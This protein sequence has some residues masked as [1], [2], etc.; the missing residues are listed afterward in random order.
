M[1]F[2]KYICPIILF[3]C[4][5][6]AF[7]FSALVIW[8][9]GRKETENRL[10]AALCLGSAIWSV[11]FG[12][13]FLQTDPEIAYRCRV[14]GMIGTILYLITGVVLV[15]Y[16]SEIKKS[17]ARVIN[18]FASTGVVIYFLTVERSQTIYQ[19]DT[20]GMTYSFKPGLANTIYTI[21]SIV[22]AVSIFAVSLYMC[23]SK[24][25]RIRHFGK[26]F[27]LM[28]GIIL[29]GTILDT[30]FPLLG[31]SAIPGSTITQFWGAIVVF[32]AIRANNRSK[33][34]IG[35]MSEY[36]YYSLSIPVLV[37][38]STRTLK[39]ANDAAA[40]FFK[41]KQETLSHENVPLDSLFEAEPEALFQFEG[42][43][44][45]IDAVFHA[46]QTYCNLS[47]NKI[48]DRYNDVIGY[49]I[50]VTDLS[51]RMKTMQ[52]LEEAKLEAESANRAKTAFLANMSHEIRTPMNA[53]M[54]FSELI[55]KMDIPDTV[56]EYVSDIRSSSQNL[57]AIINDIL[58]ISKLDSGK[59]E[60][61]CTNYLPHTLL[62]DVYHIIDVQARKKGLH[63][64]MNT[65]PR[66]PNELYGDVAR[67]RGVLINI[68]NNAIKYTQEGSV[69]FNVRLLDMQ[70]DHASLEYTITDT[71][72]GIKESALEHLFDSFARFD[73]KKNSDIEGTGL[74]LSIVN[75][76]VKLMGGTITVDS[77]YGRGSTFTV[78]LNQQ[79]IDPAPMVCAPA[80]PA[81]SADNIED[82]LKVIDT[83]V[84][85]TDDNQIN[86]K[87]IKSTLEHYGFHVDTAVSG[88]EAISLCETTDYDVIFM[89]QMMPQMDGI[90]AMEHIRALSDHYA[91]GGKG[92]IIALTANAISGVRGELMEK[93]FD[94]Y[95]SKPIAMDLLE[96]IIHSFVPAS[97]IIYGKTGTSADIF[98]PVMPKLTTTS[99]TR[100]L[101]DIDVAEGLSH[102]NGKL[103]LYM[104]ILEIA[105]RSAEKQLNDLQ[106]FYDS[107]NYTDYTIHIHSL[108]GQLL[109]MGAVALGKTAQELEYAAREGRYEVLAMQQD[110]FVT[111]Y[112]ELM[113]HIGIAINA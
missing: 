17:I 105:F 29:L 10:L 108:K 6:L 67:I 40:D 22:I 92:K 32:V 20:I 69:H 26:I 62:Q 23:F 97:R 5:V 79:V 16:L 83:R 63:F 61:S 85:V 88:P 25:R 107:Q 1:E 78:I 13:L 99:L 45:N 104:R 95:M 50:I 7:F 65:D 81:V 21:Y 73:S 42:S 87:V 59:M 54:G 2:I 103:E 100:L 3:T 4:S 30:V 14:I 51:E 38:D 82:T 39:I 60:L 57:L 53:I 91:P 80:K 64:Q 110:M 52:K 89:D 44:Q 86:L 55:L 31:M 37:Y 66:I 90:E 74:G 112:R 46:K 96:H 9:P 56:H 77:I 111:Q 33:I 93:G 113:S 36:I 106:S 12:A 58:D 11:G 49:I 34:N 28:D 70:Q 18:A 15:C 47:I 72:I 101:P 35:N 94:E 68:L 84:L 27:L 43:S 71:G 41:I 76:Y 75:G 98:A 24:I 102:C 109:N 19:L 48:T 8:S